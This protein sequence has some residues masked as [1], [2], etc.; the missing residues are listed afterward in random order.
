MPPGWRT[1]RPCSVRWP[2]QRTKTSTAGDGPDESYQAMSA[3]GRYRTHLARRALALS[4][5]CADAWAVLAA[6]ARDRASVIPLLRE[7]VAAGE[8]ALGPKVLE[9]AGHFWGLVETRPYMR[10]RFSLAEE[11]DLEEQFDEAIA[12]YRDLIRLNPGDNQGVRRPLAR[13]LAEVGRDA[14]LRVVID[15]FKDDDSPEW[16]YLDALVAFR[17]AQP[18]ANEK[19][20]RALK[21]NRHVPPFL[22][23][24]K[25]IPDPPDAYRLGS[26]EEAALATE[27]LLDAWSETPGAIHWLNTQRRT[28]KTAR[29]K[30]R[31]KG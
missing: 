13:L 15:E 8:R 22:T 5:D 11:L 28:A 27:W 10:A 16:L 14:E 26:V 21:G 30:G 17:L 2:S 4:R 25:M 31:R 18:E 23:G 19:L 7:A 24:E 29:K 3:Q 12:H 20:A 9:H 6:G 1:S